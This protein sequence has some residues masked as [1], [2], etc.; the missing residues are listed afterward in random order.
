MGKVAYLLKIRAISDEETFECA[1]EE[2]LFDMG[3]HIDVYLDVGKLK[4]KWLSTTR[5]SGRVIGDEKSRS[6]VLQLSSSHLP[7]QEQSRS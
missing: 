4:W 5:K 7:S 6:I 2:E 1:N 3:G